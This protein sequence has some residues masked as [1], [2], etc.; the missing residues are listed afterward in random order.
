MKIF[1]AEE[2]DIDSLIKIRLEFLREDF[3]D[4]TES[5]ERNITQQMKGYF[6]K[7]ISGDDFIAIL[8]EDNGSVV[9]SAFMVVVE[10]PANPFFSTGRTGTILNVFTKPEY[11]RRGIAK[12]ILLTLLDEARKLD[13]SVIDLLAT[14]DGKALYEQLGFS[15]HHN[16]YMRLKL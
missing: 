2:N 1:R 16:T 8:A 13:V 7:H 14:N 5:D 11:R 15:G 6:Q 3:P 10:R 12:M 4:M 9:S